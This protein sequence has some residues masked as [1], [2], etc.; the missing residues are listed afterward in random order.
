MVMSDYSDVK[1]ERYRDWINRAK[2]NDVPWD[3]IKYGN[4]DNDQEL[5]LFLTEQK[6]NNFWNVSSDEWKDLVSLEKEDDELRVIA[7]FSSKASIINNRAE[8]NN[9][10]MPTHKRSSWVLYKKRLKEENNFSDESIRSIG[11]SSHKILN[12]LS[13]DTSITGPVK[14]L[15]VGNVQSGKTANMAGLMALAA[16]HQWN[17]FIILSGTIDS[18]RVQTQNRLLQDLNVPGNI[19]WQGL[20]QLSRDVPETQTATQLHFSESSKDAH[21]TVCLKQYKRLEGLI[22]WLQENPQKAA[23][24]KILVIDDEADQASV[25][26]ADINSDDRKK[27]NSLITRLVSGK[28]KHGKISKGFKGYK[29]MNYIGYTATPYA[30]ILNEMGEESLYPKDF[31]M[32]LEQSNEYFGPQQIFG[33]DGINDGLNIIRKVG[34]FDLEQVRNIHD[35]KDMVLPKSLEDA[36]CWYLSSSAALRHK[37]FKKPLTMLIHTSVRTAFHTS[38]NEAI[39][40]FFKGK[41]S[42]IVEKCKII[43]ESES[44]K[45]T[46]S[47]FKSS[48]PNYG[49]DTFVLEELPKFKHFENELFEILDEK[50]K[51]I[52]IDDDKKLTFGNGLH[53]CVDNSKSA[54]NADENNYIRLAYPNSDDEFDKAPLFIVIGGATLSRGLT[55]E[56]LICSYFLRSSNAGDTL[57]QMGRWFGYRRGYELY[58]RIWMTDKSKEQFEFLSSLDD[59]LRETIKYMEMKQ[60]SPLLFGIKVKNSPSYSFLRVTSSNKMQASMED[61]LDFSGLATQVIL[62]ENDPIILQNNLKVATNFLSDLGEPYVSDNEKRIKS[63]IIFKDVSFDIIK[64]K[65][66]A[67]YHIYSKSRAL[68]HLESLIQWIDQITEDGLLTNW[69]VILAGKGIAS[70]DENNSVKQDNRFY[71]KQGSIQKVNRSKRDLERDDNVIDLGVLRTPTDIISDIDTDKF[72]SRSPKS[73]EQIFKK[74]QLLDRDYFGLEKTPQ[75]ILYCVDKNSTTNA[76]NRTNL[77]AY[78]DILGVVINIPRGDSKHGGSYAKSLVINYKEYNNNDT[79]FGKDDLNEN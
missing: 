42:V 79:F 76:L 58:P 40:I 29:A 78:D 57:M 8:V 24:M 70:F 63:N 28:N 36:L 49:G 19:R 25:N 3:K 10:E 74:P 60:Q 67:H 55:L 21:L 46:P 38:M 61:D 50:T 15:V 33:N 35:L 52:M 5:E 66:L 73:L 30:N 41:K 48:L 69:N 16:D 32:F 22:D 13:A 17:M 11:E 54:E 77:D 53:I 1:Y 62:Y 44:Q 56:G 39:Q 51:T 27:I 7:G 68:G 12:N 47:G 43:W 9:L 45:L 20:E 75:L 37:G 4:R 72:D 2:E 65:F 23:Q 71:I 18:L 34:E 26:T 6:N 59:E 14:G 31:I 64:K